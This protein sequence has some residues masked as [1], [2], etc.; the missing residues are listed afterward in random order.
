MDLSTIQFGSLFSYSSH[1]D[2]D[3]EKKSKAVMVSLKTDQFLV[4][5]PPISMSDFISDTIKKNM[6]TLPFAHFLQIY[7]I[8]VPIP[9]SS[10]MKPDT[11]W[12]PQRLANAL[13]R[14]GFGKTVVE[15]LERVCPLRKS[16]TSLSSNRPKAREHY[17]SFGVRKKIFPEPEEILLVDDVVTRGATIVGAANKLHDTFP[18]ADIRA[19]AAMRT[20]SSPEDFKHIY[21]PCEGKITLIDEDTFREP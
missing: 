9:K 5:K 19:F 20:I 12:V 2:S 21:D 4:S 18:R 6:T 14:N 3:V 15:Y 13:I 17:D 1:G 10:W 11:L 7:P 16:A 8:L